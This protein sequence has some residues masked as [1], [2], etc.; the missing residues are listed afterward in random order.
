ME[1]LNFISFTYNR[2]SQLDTRAL[3][4]IK[5]IN[6]EENT[7]QAAER[8]EKKRPDDQKWNQT[9]ADQ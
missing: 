3:S 2:S 7:E 6:P 8:E 5:S 4:L 1:E 9:P